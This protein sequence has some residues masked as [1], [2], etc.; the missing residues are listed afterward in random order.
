[1][2]CLNSK[3]VGKLSMAETKMCR[4]ACFLAMKAIGILAM[5]FAAV[6]SPANAQIQSEIPGIRFK[7]APVVSVSEAQ[8]Y[9]DTLLSSATY[10]LAQPARRDDICEL[11]SQFRTGPLLG[12][13]SGERAP[14]DPEQWYRFVRDEVRFT[15]LFGLKKGAFGAF[16][17]RHGTSFDQAELVHE[18]AL[19]LGQTSSIEVVFVDLSAADATAWLS[20]PDLQ[21]VSEVFA[22][23][24]IPHEV[25]GSTIT[26]MHAVAVVNGQRYDPSIKRMD[27]VTSPLIADIMASKSSQIGAVMDSAAANRAITSNTVNDARIEEFPESS[28]APLYSGLD[29]W[30][31]SLSSRLEQNPGAVWNDFLG[32]SII[33]PGLEDENEIIPSSYTVYRSFSPREDGVSTLPD[34]FNTSVRLGS[35]TRSMSH[36]YGHRT[37]ILTGSSPNARTD[38][39]KLWAD[40]FDL[41]LYVSDNIGI[42]GF[43]I[44]NFHAF[45]GPTVCMHNYGADLS[46]YE[47]PPQYDCEDQYVQIALRGYPLSDPNVVWPDD[48]IGEDGNVIVDASFDGLRNLEEFPLIYVRIDHPYPA[49]S[50]SYADE[51]IEKQLELRTYNEFVIDSGRSENFAYEYYMRVKGSA[52]LKSDRRFCFGQ[53][54]DPSGNY[55]NVT[56]FNFES[57]YI[58]QNT[59]KDVIWRRW[60]VAFSKILELVD[61]ATN[62]NV[63][64]VRHHSIGFVSSSSSFPVNFLYVTFDM[65]SLFSIPGDQ[66]DDGVFAAKYTISSMHTVLEAL[67]TGEIGTEPDDQDRHF[68][69]YNERRLWNWNKRLFVNKPGYSTTSNLKAVHPRLRETPIRASDAGAYILYPDRSQGDIKYGGGLLAVAE[70]GSS[71]SPYVHFNVLRPEVD[72]LHLYGR[73]LKG[74]AS[75]PSGILQYQLPVQDRP[76][77]QG[78]SIPGLSYS[79]DGDFGLSGVV[80]LGTG[81]S[82]MS[83]LG[84]EGSLSLGSVSAPSTRIASSKWTTG[85]NDITRVAEANLSYNLMSGRAHFANLMWADRDSSLPAAFPALVSVAALMA[86]LDDVTATPSATLTLEDIKKIDSAEFIVSW[87]MAQTWLGEVHVSAP[88]GF[89]ATYYRDAATYTATGL[90]GYSNPRRSADNIDPIQCD[91][92]RTVF[93]WDY[94]QYR[95]RCPRDLIVTTA[96]GVEYRF[97]T[98]THY[99]TGSDQQDQPNDYRNGL[100]SEITYPNG[101]ILDFE[102]DTY[103]PTTTNEL[104]I[105]NGRL[106]KVSNNL[107]REIDLKWNTQDFY[108][109]D[110]RLLGVETES[111]RSIDFGLFVGAGRNEN[112]YTQGLQVAC[113]NGTDSYTAPRQAGLSIESSDGRISYLMFDRAPVVRISVSSVCYGG[114]NHKLG[115]REIDIYDETFLADEY[116]IMSEND[117]RFRLVFDPRFGLRKIFYRNEGGALE[118]GGEVLTA[119]GYSQTV[120]DAV[121]EVSTVFDYSE[122]HVRRATD[123]V[124]RKTEVLTDGRGLP[125]ETILRDVGDSESVYQARSETVYNEFGLPVEGTQFPRTGLSANPI[126]TRTYY[127][128]TNWPTKP[129]KIVDGE[130]V[131]TRMAYDAATGLLIEEIGPFRDAT[132]TNSSDDPTCDLSGE[133]GCVTTTYKSVNGVQMVDQVREL[134]EP[135]VC[136]VTTF[137]YFGAADFYNVQSTSASDTCVLN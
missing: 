122:Y 17:D 91:S 90:D 34:A 84:M 115:E 38:N 120:F 57:S 5:A 50:G 130:G 114:L 75:V 8:S 63:R 15:P 31:E 51:T 121:G 20:L 32:G 106:E 19:C 30:V 23:G 109:D 79:L 99:V 46:G 35:L 108:D 41:L 104:Y 4:S 124:G 60:S 95:W 6:Y 26:F 24:G 47:A 110:H 49:L 70:D 72:K 65:D 29:G 112:N 44:D 59:N 33:V 16:V 27:W 9:F 107:G 2:K 105:V 13:G 53:N 129:T 119:L 96:E 58:D 14:G 78:F 40:R 80:G 126:I 133:Y 43:E 74:G 131:A 88:D 68:I 7:Q 11:A 67:M 100:L 89:S 56:T 1:M 101:L 117:I 12:D 48:V 21:A 113:P 111:G 118:L 132:P 3:W 54:I 61:I 73:L 36:F 62:G 103:V 125:I 28:L 85:L 69:S 123:A 77:S 39:D 135:N 25:S 102:Y 136:R 87:F 22:A 37:A 92:Y 134:I 55:C 82:S 45:Y 66:S 81:G 97:D 86:S 71:I 116:A 137:S 52:D 64:P 93:H 98:F 42:N 127:E 10:E 128:D 18:I 76:E 94:F 83:A